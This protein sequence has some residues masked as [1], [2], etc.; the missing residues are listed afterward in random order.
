MIQRKIDQLPTP[1]RDLLLAA[2]VQG[3]EFDSFV[4][5]RA[6]GMDAAGAEDVLRDLDQVHAFI[7]GV[8]PSS[9][10]SV[11][12]AET[13]AFVHILYQNALYESLTS[14]RRA[15]QSSSRRGPVGAPSQ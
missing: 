10:R 14:A 7:G 9:D 6:A 8:V 4:V 13:Y 2:A 1:S 15:A 12:Q 3:T 5:A 11:S